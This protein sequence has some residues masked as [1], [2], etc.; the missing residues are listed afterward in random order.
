VAQSL[1]S[2]I[3]KGELDAGGKLPSESHL[4]AMLGVSRTAVRE[5][6]KALA[7]INMLTVY[8]DC[9]AFVHEDSNG[10]VKDGG[11]SIALAPWAL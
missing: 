3:S 2:L 9:G 5:G 7:G 10:M 1:L 11:L 4:C 6:I 8:P